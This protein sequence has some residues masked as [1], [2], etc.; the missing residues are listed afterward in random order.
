MTLSVISRIVYAFSWHA[1]AVFGFGGT[2]ASLIAALLLVYGI[3]KGVTAK[4]S[5]AT[6][7]DVLIIDCFV[8]TSEPP[9]TVWEE[10]AYS[11]QSWKP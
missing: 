8:L 1:S 2:L 3:D 5:E 4:E 11:F 6:N 10:Q 9:H 7:R